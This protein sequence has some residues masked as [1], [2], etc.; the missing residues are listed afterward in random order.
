MKVATYLYQFI[1]FHD[2]QVG[3]WSTNTSPKNFKI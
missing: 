2:I 3:P 1:T